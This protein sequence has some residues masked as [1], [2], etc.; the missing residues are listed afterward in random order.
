MES[1]HK[2]MISI[3]LLSL[4]AIRVIVALAQILVMEALMVMVITI[5]KMKI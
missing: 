5:K 2:E 1:R 3:N 4:R